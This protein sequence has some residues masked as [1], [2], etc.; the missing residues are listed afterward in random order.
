MLAREADS[1]PNRAKIAILLSAIGPDALERYNHFKWDDPPVDPPE[2]ADA[3]QQGN[4][5]PVHNYAGQAMC[6]S[7]RRL[8]G[9]S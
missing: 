6:V 3:D 4:V 8:C 9:R 5:Q 2:P 1:K 7:K